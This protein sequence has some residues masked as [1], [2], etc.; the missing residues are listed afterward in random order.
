M[1]TVFVTCLDLISSRRLRTGQCHVFCFLILD[2]CCSGKFTVRILYQTQHSTLMPPINSQLPILLSTPL[3]ISA[4][5]AYLD[6]RIDKAAGEPKTR[7]TKCRLQ[8]ES[9]PRCKVSREYLVP[10]RRLQ[11]NRQAEI[12]SRFKFTTASS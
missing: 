12:F 8:Q 11:Q 4:E 3:N 5:L 6:Q 9:L 10:H 1:S 7:V 2:N